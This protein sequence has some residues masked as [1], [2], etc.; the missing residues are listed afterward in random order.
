MLGFQTLLR[1]IVGGFREAMGMCSLCGNQSC[2]SYV[3]I[4]LTNNSGSAMQWK[5]AFNNQYGNRLELPG[6]KRLG[7]SLSGIDG[8]SLV[9]LSSCGSFRGDD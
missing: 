7:A 6:R 2:S 1:G 9:T 3:A 8:T 4:K 5:C